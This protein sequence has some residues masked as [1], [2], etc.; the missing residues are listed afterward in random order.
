MAIR[1]QFRNSEIGHDPNIDIQ[2]QNQG[3]KA[4]SSNINSSIKQERLKDSKANRNLRICYAVIAVCFAIASIIFWMRFIQFYYDPK[5]HSDTVFITI[6]SACTVNIL[7]A[8][9]SI[10]KGLFPSKR[11]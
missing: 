3:L 6:T 9:I 8:F 1:S 11:K 7:A 5:K 4:P 10:I 2:Y